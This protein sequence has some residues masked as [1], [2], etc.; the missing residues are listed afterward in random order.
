LWI[1]TLRA[2]DKLSMTS[3]R[4][5]PPALPHYRT[6]GIHQLRSGKAKP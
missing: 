5:M 1:L 6:A 2:E 3:G 4:Q